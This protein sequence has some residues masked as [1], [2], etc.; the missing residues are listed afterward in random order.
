[1]L[2]MPYWAAYSPLLGF[3][4]NLSTVIVILRAFC[5]HALKIICMLGFYIHFVFDFLSIK[6]PYL[7]VIYTNCV[8]HIFNHVLVWGGETKPKAGKI[9]QTSPAVDYNIFVKKC[10]YQVSLSRRI[11]HLT[12]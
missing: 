10:S 7:R 9:T 12:T 8:T 11:W 5:C 6:I 3:I 1:M 4:K 2:S